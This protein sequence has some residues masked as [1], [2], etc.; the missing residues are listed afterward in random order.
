MAAAAK[1]LDAEFLTILR[2]FFFC[3][4]RYVLNVTSNKKATP[5]CI[6]ASRQISPGK[7]PKKEQ[8]G[9]LWG[10]EFSAK[11]FL[12]HWYLQCFPAMKALK[13]LF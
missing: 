13:P 8:N 11:I 5:H 6:P 3:I 1:F 4:L 12:K 2:I 9:S 10:G 7:T